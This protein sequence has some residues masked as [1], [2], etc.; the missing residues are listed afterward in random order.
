MS[1]R[2]RVEICCE[3]CANTAELTSAASSGSHR[4][5]RLVKPVGWARIVV[6]VKSDLLKPVQVNRSID[7]CPD[8]VKATQDFLDPI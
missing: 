3:R 6:T 4:G 2:R 8:C 1:V 5:G 7:I